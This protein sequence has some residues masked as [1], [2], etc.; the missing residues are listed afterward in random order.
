MAISEK[1]GEE[2]IVDLPQ[3]RLAYRERGSGPPI[4]FVHG[5]LVNG[6]LWRDVVD[7]LAPRHRCITPDWPLGSHPHPME[8][9]AD[10]ST[11][12][13]A[14]LAAD[15]LDALD[16]R[17]VT[18]VGND[19]GGAICQLLVT[20]HPARVARLVL[21][22][23]D[24][25]EVFPPQPFGFLRWV[26]RIPGAAAVVAHS[27]RVRPLRG[28]PLA[29]GWVVTGR[30]PR[31]ISDSYVTQGYRRDIRRDTKKVL[32]GISNRDT[33]AAAEGFPSV[34]M[35]VLIAWA[36]EDKLF[37]R[38]LAERLEQAFPNARRVTIEGSRT[39]IGEDQPERLAEAIATF[40]RGSVHPA[41]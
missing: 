27:M 30:L 25:F 32:R 22:S 19:T 18:L 11:P 20:R 7:V 10:L 26:G 4:V 41:R 8:P 9:A 6:D 36:G 40:V 13:L 3:G 28:L 34:Q 38:H 16:V 21:T 39:F 12:G 33:L 29:F 14:R 15:F 31:A 17:E 2:R 24:A 35:P 37:P 5:V 1:L 23:C